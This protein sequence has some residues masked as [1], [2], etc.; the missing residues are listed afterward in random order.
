MKVIPLISKLLEEEYLEREPSDANTSSDEDIDVNVHTLI[1][2]N[3]K[4]CRHCFIQY[5]RVA[6][7]L[8]ALK[9]NVS[10]AVSV[11]SPNTHRC[12]PDSAL[13][14]SA[15]SSTPKRPRLCVFCRA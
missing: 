9:G 11:L 3:G 14:A 2:N 8:D 7:L 5:N 6:D 1:Y 12:R 4:M 15:V 10:N 13:D